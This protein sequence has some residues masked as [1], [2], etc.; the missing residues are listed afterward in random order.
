[1]E[2][3]EVFQ[4]SDTGVGL[5]FA[6]DLTQGKKNLF[7]VVRNHDSEGGHVVNGERLGNWSRERLGEEGN[8]ALGLAVLREELGLERVVFLG[9]EER[10]GTQ[11]ALSFLL[12]WHLMVEKLLDVIDGQKVLAVHGDDNS[13]PD[14]GDEDLGLVLDL[15]I[16]RG[17]DLG[18]DTLGQTG[19]DVSPRSPDRGTKVER[20]GNREDGVDQDVPQ[21]GIKEEEDHTSED[22]QSQRDLRLVRAEIFQQ[23]LVPKT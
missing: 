2:L 14:L 19:V 13:I 12:R 5:I 22:H 20:S 4:E 23:K 15:H 6:N 3:L 10:R 8:S 11:S 16:G 17:K 7:A 9:N 1:M 21:I 18:V